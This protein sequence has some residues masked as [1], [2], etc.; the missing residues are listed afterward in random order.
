MVMDVNTVCTHLSCLKNNQSGVH[1]PPIHSNQIKSC[2]VLSSVFT[3]FSCV[4]KKQSGVH[5]LPINCNQTKNRSV[6]STYVSCLQRLQCDIHL[7][8]H[9]H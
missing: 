8:F 7:Q 4:R 3:H 9:G 6:L 5:E 2:S 1:G